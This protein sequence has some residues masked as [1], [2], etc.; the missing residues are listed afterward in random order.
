M[1]VTLLYVQLPTMVIPRC[2]YYRDLIRFR[3]SGD[4]A[5]MLQSIN[6]REAALI[7]RASGMKY[8]ARNARTLQLQPKSLFALTSW[9]LLP[10][11]LGVCLLVAE[12][13]FG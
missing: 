13:G 11:W 2:R 8:D 7:D 9:T 6:P 4:P 12:C 5:I 1:C 10:A 3:N